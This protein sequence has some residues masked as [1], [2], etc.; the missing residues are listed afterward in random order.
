MFCECVSHQKNAS[1]GMFWKKVV[2]PF[3]SF[4][5]SKQQR[6]KKVVPFL[7]R[8]ST[9]SCL[10][11]FVTFITIFSDRYSN[12]TTIK[13]LVLLSWIPASKEFFEI[14]ISISIVNVW[15]FHPV[16]ETT[17]NQTWVNQKSLETC[18]VS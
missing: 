1:F 4:I 10:D 2:K 18:L 13:I 17:S 7:A 9:I 16:Y 6:S 11:T 12:L 5:L 14:H 8:V 3:L 15:F